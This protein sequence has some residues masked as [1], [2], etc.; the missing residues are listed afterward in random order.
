MSRGNVL[1][2]E[3]PSNILRYIDVDTIHR[4]VL[5]ESIK[6]NGYPYILNRAH[7]YAVLRWTDRDEIED[8][9]ARFMGVPSQYLYTMKNILK[10][11]SIV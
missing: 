2:V 4:A 3:F 8:Y 9:I 10:W 1:R 11:R 6:G 5:L 7:E